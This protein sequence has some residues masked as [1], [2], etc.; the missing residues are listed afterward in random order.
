MQVLTH[1]H[2]TEVKDPYGGIG[3]RIEGAEGEGDPIGRLSVS[4]N[5]KIPD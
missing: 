4:T 5:L 3:G 2:W 1:N